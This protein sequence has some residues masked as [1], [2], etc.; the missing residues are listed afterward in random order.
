[1]VGDVVGNVVDVGDVGDVASSTILVSALINA[2]R[3][4]ARL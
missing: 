3:K 1:M 4:A 2:E